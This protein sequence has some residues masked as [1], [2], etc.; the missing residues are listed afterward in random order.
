MISAKGR[1]GHRHP[2]YVFTEYGAV[3]LSS[4]LNT[5]TAVQASILIARAFV[6]LREVISSHTELARKIDELERQVR[7]HGVHIH[8]LFD[9]IR[10]LLDPPIPLRREI[11]FKVGT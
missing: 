8:A 11:G 7:G 1:G 10:K 3:M 2:P 9:S 6:R 4:V 5:P